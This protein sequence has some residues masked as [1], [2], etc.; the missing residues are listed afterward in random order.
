MSSGGLSGWTTPSKSL[1]YCSGPAAVAVDLRS[2]FSPNAP[3]SHTK[4]RVFF[5]NIFI[6]AAEILSPIAPQGEM[7]EDQRTKYYAEWKALPNKQWI[8]ERSPSVAEIRELL[9]AWLSHTAHF[10]HKSRRPLQLR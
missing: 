9:A 2:I 3:E 7:N 4:W 5:R 8:R 10:K 1:L 6:G